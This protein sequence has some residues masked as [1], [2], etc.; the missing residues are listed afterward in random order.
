M[1]RPLYIICAEAGAEDKST[2]RVSHFNVIEKISI[3]K[4]PISP[5]GQAIVRILPLIVTAVW[6]ATP[7]DEA[8]T[9][10][11]QFVFK[12]EPGGKRDIITQ[13]KFL[14]SLPMH[15]FSLQ[16]PGNRH[17]QFGSFYC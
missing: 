7:G 6:I 15:R 3:S 2:G 13:D 11:Y 10:E 14:F 17:G 16:V 12:F 1:A 9:F 5:G 4:A 8:F